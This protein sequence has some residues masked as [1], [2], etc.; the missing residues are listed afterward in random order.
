MIYALDY[1]SIYMYI[2]NKMIN[3]HN[4]VWNQLKKYSVTI[5]ESHKSKEIAIWYLFNSSY[6]DRGQCFL[7]MNGSA[8]CQ[9]VGLKKKLSP[10][11]QCVAIT[12]VWWDFIFTSGQQIEISLLDVG[13]LI[14]VLNL[15][16]ICI[17]YIKLN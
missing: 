2:K 1:L 6:C 5:Y 12:N 7:C 13:D 15:I 11:P 17:A 16:D 8:I 4:L 3:G 10:M 9:L 14:F